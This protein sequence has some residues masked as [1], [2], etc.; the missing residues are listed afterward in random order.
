MAHTEASE[1]RKPENLENPQAR[2]D[3]AAVSPQAAASN[4][5]IENIM[6]PMKHNISPCCD[7]NDCQL[8]LDSGKRPADGVRGFDSPC[9]EAEVGRDQPKAAALTADEGPKAAAFIK[10]SHSPPST[11]PT[12]AA[13]PQGPLQPSRESSAESTHPAPAPAPEQRKAQRRAAKAQRK[14]QALQPSGEAVSVVKTGLDTESSSQASKAGSLQQKLGTEA[15]IRTNPPQNDGIS[16][17][18]KPTSQAP[19]SMPADLPAA[20]KPHITASGPANS[21]GKTTAAAGS[22]IAT[23]GPPNDA[24]QTEDD[25]ASSARPRLSRGRAA[26]ARKATEEQ[27]PVPNLNTDFPALGAPSSCDNSRQQAA[28]APAPT[29][30]PVR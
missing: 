29:K 13:Q 10:S 26:P 25:V 18:L 16:G 20:R 22:A 2:T 21:V 7:A 5:H 12:P 28:S 6:A 27:Q 11:P 1:G 19:I 3:T 14:L 8:D 9:E 15:E 30:A 17:Q 23:H 24:T 4:D